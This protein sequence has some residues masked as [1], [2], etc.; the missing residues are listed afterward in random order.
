M[1]GSGPGFLPPGLPPLGACILACQEPE[2]LVCI[3]HQGPGPCLGN[4]RSPG[5]QPAGEGGS[6]VQADAALR[7]AR[8]AAGASPAQRNLSRLVAPNAGLTPH[9]WNSAGPSFWAGWEFQG[10]ETHP[11][12]TV[13][14]DIHFPFLNLSFPVC[15]IIMITPASQGSGED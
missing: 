3:W 2:L 8:R 13:T 6:V 9:S 10:R 4:L 14:L 1:P 5:S 12:L 7:R 15:K 11:R